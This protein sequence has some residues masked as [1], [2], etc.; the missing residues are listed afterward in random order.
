[1]GILPEPLIG[2]DRIVSL[3]RVGLLAGMRALRPQLRASAPKPHTT[4][5]SVLQAS[6]SP[7]GPPHQRLNALE[8]S[9][10]RP[11]G[12]ATGPPGARSVPVVDS[13]SAIDTL[14]A[15]S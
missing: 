3:G 5:E 1:M 13:R 9:E 10:I 4:L 15:G 14:A 12:S 7:Q 2:L 8:M 6:A 11:P